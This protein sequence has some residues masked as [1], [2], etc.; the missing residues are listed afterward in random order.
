MTDIERDNLYTELCHTM[1][2]LG[3]QRAPLFLARFALLA[4]DAVGQAEVVQGLLRD[5]AAG[6]AE[7]A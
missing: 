3:E 1:G 4:M 5:A 2:S 6:M 7:P